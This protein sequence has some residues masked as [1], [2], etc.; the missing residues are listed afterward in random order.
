MLM[1]EKY[2]R[3]EVELTQ[4]HSQFVYNHQPPTNPNMSYILLGVFHKYFCDISRYVLSKSC[5]C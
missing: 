5:V 1:N 2:E 4:Q 3:K